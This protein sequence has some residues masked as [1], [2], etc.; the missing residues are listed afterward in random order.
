MNSNKRGFLKAIN[1]LNLNGIQLVSGKHE[2]CV[3]SLL[4]GGYK[5][6]RLANFNSSDAHDLLENIKCFGVAEAYRLHA[7]GN[8]STGVKSVCKQKI[9]DAHGRSR[10]EII[11]NAEN[12]SGTYADRFSGVQFVGQGLYN[13]F[14]MYCECDFTVLNYKEWL[15]DMKTDKRFGAMSKEKFIKFVKDNYI[16]VDENIIPVKDL[17]EVI[18]QWTSENNYNAFD[19][20]KKLYAVKT[21]EN[22]YSERLMAG[23][24]K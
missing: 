5:F 20:N 2:N 6:D 12:Q 1:D 3:I 19:D 14:R 11:R 9:N 21:F 10:D 18:D 23:L 22:M 13:V 7:S 16:V 15:K 4:Y 24:V 17:F 8:S